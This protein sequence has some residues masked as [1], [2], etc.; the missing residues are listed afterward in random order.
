M[1]NLTEEQL[2]ARKWLK[3]EK[4]IAELQEANYGGFRKRTIKAVIFYVLFM[5]MYFLLS[6][7]NAQENN[8]TKLNIVKQEKG[9]ASYIDGDYAVAYFGDACFWCTEG[10][11]DNIE[12]VMDV[13]SGYL[14]GTHP[15]APTYTN[16]GN[17]AEGN[18]I[19]YDPLVV[20]FKELVN[21]YFLVH[22]FGKSPDVGE[23]YRAVIH[24]P[25]Y[26]NYIVE[27]WADAIKVNGKSFDQQVILGEINWFDA[28]D[29]HQ[30]YLMRLEGGES[31]ANPGYGRNESIPR[32]NKALKIVKKYQRRMK[33]TDAQA[34]IL[35]KSGTERAYSSPLNSEKRS[36]SYVSP[37]TGDVLF[38][39]SA[40]FNSGT[41]WPSFDAATDKVSLGPAE[42]GGY[43][44]IEKSTG[45]HLGHLFQGEMFTEENKRYCINGNALI[46]VPDGI[47]Q[48]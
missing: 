10:I 2:A 43:E 9:N 23:S 37:A 4:K 24:A 5:G 26:H 40:K 20:S 41:G 12:G 14:G 16:H 17:Y 30:D 13:K 19:T 33:L 28:E 27:Y 6:S 35:L 25:K 15:E 29:Y 21:F 47:P 39:S 32:R 45:Y 31:V 7:C 44:V 38:H 11:W 1:T 48:N 3:N 36:G 46:F 8:K 34:Y 42:Q 22:S 18:R